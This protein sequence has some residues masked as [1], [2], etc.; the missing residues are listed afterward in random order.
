[1]HFL[2]FL[3]HFENLLALLILKVF[4]IAGNYLFSYVGKGA[5]LN[6]IQ[7]IIIISIWLQKLT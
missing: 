6:F 7:I 3:L 5:H 4:N 2:Q 1:M